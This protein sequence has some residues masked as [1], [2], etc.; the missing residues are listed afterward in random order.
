MVRIGQNREGRWLLVLD[1][2]NDTQ[3]QYCINEECSGYDT[4]DEL[5][6]LARGIIERSCRQEVGEDDSKMFI[7]RMLHCFVLPK[8]SFHRNDLEKVE[9]AKNEQIQ[10]IHALDNKL[11]TKCYEVTECQDD[12]DMIREQFL[13]S[14]EEMIS[15]NHCDKQ[16]LE[17]L[18]QDLKQEEQRLRLQ[19]DMAQDDVESARVKA[20]VSNSSAGLLYEAREKRDS[21][22]NKL[23][24]LI[25]TAREEIKEDIH[26]LRDMVNVQP[27]ATLQEYKNKRTTLHRLKD[28]RSKLTQQKNCA[29]SVREMLDEILNDLNTQGYSETDDAD[30]KGV[31]STDVL[32]NVWHPE[33]QKLSERVATIVYNPE[34]PVGNSFVKFCSEVHEMCQ[35]LIKLGRLSSSAVDVH[36]RESMSTLSIPGSNGVRPE[37]QLGNSYDSYALNDFVVES[38]RDRLT[39][40]KQ[41]I[42]CHLDKMTELL[43]DQFNNRDM[44]FRNKLRLAYEHCF[45]EKEHQF[46]ECVYELAHHEHVASLES[47]IKRLKKLPI[48][49]LKLPMKDEWWH[50]IFERR[51]R[52][53]ELNA[54]VFKPLAQSMSSLEEMNG[55]CDDSEDESSIEDDLDG[56]EVDFPFTMNGDR[57]HVLDTMS[58]RS[59]FINTVR[60][61]SKTFNC[62]FSSDESDSED[63]INGASSK[64]NSGP[65]LSSSAPTQ[66]KLSLGNLIDQWQTKK[67]LEKESL[68]RRPSKSHNEISQTKSVRRR[69][70][71][72]LQEG[73]TFEDHFGP[74]LE[75]MK[76]MLNAISP[77][78]KLK[79][80][81]ASL[82]KIASKVSELRMRD[83]RD[84][85]SSA[86]TA[87]DLLPLL[88]LMMLQME[89]CEAASMWPQLAMLEDLMAP[90]LSSGCH[91]WALVEFQM[92]QRILADLCSQF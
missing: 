42:F 21:L 76:D 80:L 52:I 75:H 34:H 27:N 20:S 25:L 11:K 46:I 6:D 45:Y 67:N 41:I 50:E 63:E 10:N 9:L 62:D 3:N 78:A 61:R 15:N 82:R 8:V 33:W 29:L 91:G 12:L 56:L 69:S 72:E 37:D 18:L 60:D 51:V 66:S 39:Q 65:N 14:I 23:S 5:F 87:E 73:D 38:Y 55:D 40:L 85:F 13:P 48:K 88:I 19:I 16:F 59:F 71:C 81:T 53:C 32:Q 90:C 22:Q 28:D 36:G 1:D 74:A 43:S 44:P 17:S 30:S 24:E 47:D 2:E 77:V 68:K 64:L 79:C 84:S 86:V 58:V 89:P 35:D 57:E 49:L 7:L 92:A 31:R 4:E 70:S 54:Q 83:G 26:N